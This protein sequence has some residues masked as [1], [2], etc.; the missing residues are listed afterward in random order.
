MLFK[1]DKDGSG[2]LSRLPL[3]N[4]HA[5][6]LE[7]SDSLD[8]L[9]GGTL[10]F[11]K[12]DQGFLFFQTLPDVQLFFKSLNHENSRD[13]R[14]RPLGEQTLQIEPEDPLCLGRKVPYIGHEFAVPF[15]EFFPFREEAA[16]IGRKDPG[17]QTL[18]PDF[19]PVEVA[20]DRL[21]RPEHIFERF[22]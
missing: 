15:F 2:L 22:V 18:E 5:L 13:L 7:I 3:K 21:F 6:V 1:V 19:E 10:F 17:R 9:P 11:E 12:T 16:K 14:P 20:I 8:K 4:A